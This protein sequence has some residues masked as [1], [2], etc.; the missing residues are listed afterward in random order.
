M[1]SLL[2]NKN[3]RN[4]DWLQRNFES[5][6]KQPNLRSMISQRNLQLSSKNISHT[7]ELSKKIWSSIKRLCR[8]F[9]MK[10]SFTN[11][12]RKQTGMRISKNG[13]FLHS[14]LTKKMETWLSLILM[15]RCVQNNQE[16]KGSYYSRN[17]SQAVG[18]L[19]HQSNG[20]M[21]IL[22]MTVSYG[23]ISQITTPST[24]EITYTIQI[25]NGVP[26]TKTSQI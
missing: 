4:K 13:P 15:G 23:L 20:T 17:S 2:K 3:Y 1:F 22:E 19:H 24:H 12:D 10:M 25:W 9:L 11:W 26:S 18:N 16:M 7:S 8:R 14:S 6:T 21:T 5:D